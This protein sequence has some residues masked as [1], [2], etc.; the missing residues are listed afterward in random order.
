MLH[1]GRQLIKVPLPKMPP[2]TL[3]AFGVWEVT[4]GGGGGQMLHG[5]VVTVYEGGG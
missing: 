1:G 2:T 5:I 3:L 4:W